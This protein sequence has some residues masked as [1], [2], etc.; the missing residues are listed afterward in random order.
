MKTYHILEY[1]RP[2]KTHPLSQ[3]PHGF[4]GEKVTVNGHV[5]GRRL[6]NQCSYRHPLDANFKKTKRCNNLTNYDYTRCDQCLLDYYFLAVGPSRLPNAG[7]GLFAVDPETYAKQGFKKDET[8]VIFPRGS[9]VGMGRY[10]C[11]EMLSDRDYNERYRH[12]KGKSSSIYALCAPMKGKTQDEILAR[13]ILSYGND[14]I[15]TEHPDCVR[16]YWDYEGRLHI[17]APDW[18]Y[19]IN[20]YPDTINGT[21][22]CLRALT[23]IHHGDEIFWSYGNILGASKIQGKWKVND[24]GKYCDSYWFG[25]V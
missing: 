2:E 21:Y 18:P 4:I 13:T 24:K 20:A 14:A 9:F 12:D 19:V 16:N 25:L 22:I 7:R 5:F 3:L 1:V 15:Y 17:V 11:G 8:K 6:V 23:D 10:F